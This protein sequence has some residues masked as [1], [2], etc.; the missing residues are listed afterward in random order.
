MPARRTLARATRL[1]AW[2]PFS[3]AHRRVPISTAGSGNS[4][5]GNSGNSGRSGDE[6][7]V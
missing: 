1:P 5:R 2:I 6:E 4:G 3:T 7:G